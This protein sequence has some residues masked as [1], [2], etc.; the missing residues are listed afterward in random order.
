LGAKEVIRE[1]DNEYITP[2]LHELAIMQYKSQSAH[3]G[4]DARLI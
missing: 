4:G 2:I 1:A 3:I